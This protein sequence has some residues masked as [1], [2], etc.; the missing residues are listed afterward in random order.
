MAIDA[1]RFEELEIKGMISIFTYGFD[2]SYN[3][4]RDKK[5]ASTHLVLMIT[6]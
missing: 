6:Y 2:I 5:M 4:F 1:L 3:N